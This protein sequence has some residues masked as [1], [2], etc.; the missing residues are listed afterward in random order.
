MIRSN[1]GI[2]FYRLT[3]SGILLLCL[4]QFACDGSGKHRNV[5]DN[6]T[7]GPT[8]VGSDQDAQ[9]V[10][11][12]STPVNVTGTYL[13]NFD[14][15]RIRCDYTQQS[16]TNYTSLCV[17]VV[18]QGDGSELKAAKLAGG[19]SL[20]WTQ[21]QTSM[22]SAKVGACQVAGD[23]LSYT[24]NVATS[25]GV[26]MVQLLFSLQ[27][28]D[29]LKG[30][31]SETASL[32][33]P[34]AV[35]VSAGYAP[36][37]PFQ[38]SGQTSAPLSLTLSLDA[39]VSP[40]PQ[41]VGFQQI[42][43]PADTINFSQPDAFCARDN[44]LFFVQG[45]F[46]Y[47]LQ[48][49]KVT[50]YAGSSQT[51]SAMN[52]SHRLRI[53]IAPFDLLCDKDAIYVSSA[54]FCRILRITDDGPVTIVTGK[55]GSCA[56]TPDGTS[57]QN[58]AHPPLSML[59]KAPTG[60]LIFAEVTGRIREITAQGTLKTLGDVG[61][62]AD[63]TDSSWSPATAPNYIG[64]L[65]VDAAGNIFV[66]DTAAQTVSKIDA[67]G[68]V[69]RVAGT[70]IV[71]YKN[72]S[73]PLAL[74]DPT[75]LLFDVDGALLIGEAFRGIKK[76]KADGS[77][78]T[79]ISAGSDINMELMRSPLETIHPIAMQRPNFTGILRQGDG[80]LQTGG[81]RGIMRYLNPSAQP[82]Y[83]VGGDLTTPPCSASV[84][85][86]QQRLMSPVAI[87]Y[88]GSDSL[89]VVDYQSLDS[90]Q[91]VIWGISQKA[92]ISYRHHRP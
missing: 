53:A 89:L 74:A 77:L 28:S 27:I 90:N 7:S 76:L 78:S 31:R 9:P 84:E 11:T 30:E 35:G 1:K 46:V 25:S 39:T 81:P 22:G 86:S 16:S 50:L 34:Y 44:R 83:I 56:S 24:C 10:E 32:T 14:N 42:S 69:S 19:T 40:A 8:K 20:S 64:G 58:A 73:N 60:E 61:S 26:S 2:Q 18:A 43:Y 54:V 70:G 17:V 82:T 59:A 68:R 92:G 67:K 91:L 4:F 37:V 55:E 63:A 79:V 5:S 38:Y 88:A 13:A 72:P 85:A 21:P 87:T 66:A 71:R 51:G 75:R 45:N 29:A 33:L 6:K 80:S 57:A 15:S 36:S 12:A 23:T 52:T 62:D 65:A 41:K 48:N 49:G 47:Q 3:A